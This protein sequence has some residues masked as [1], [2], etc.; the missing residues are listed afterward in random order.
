MI[1]LLKTTEKTLSPN[2]DA[3]FHPEEVE[4]TCEKAFIKFSVKFCNLYSHANLVKDTVDSINQHHT[5]WTTISEYHL[6]IL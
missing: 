4:Y 6:P 1:D 2:L 3:Y 5:A